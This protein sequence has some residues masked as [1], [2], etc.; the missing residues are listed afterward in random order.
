MNELLPEPVTPRKMIILSSWDAQFDD[1]DLI[2]WT[3]SS[4]AGG[5][6]D[7]KLTRFANRDIVH[8]PGFREAAMSHKVHNTSKH[9]I[10]GWGR[11]LCYPSNSVTSS[12]DSFQLGGVPTSYLTILEVEAARWLTGGGRSLHPTT[13]QKS[14]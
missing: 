13:A 3:F 14:I 7:S 6:R 12:M 4:L 11:R 9:W 5:F 2:C 8:W 10:Q 1:G